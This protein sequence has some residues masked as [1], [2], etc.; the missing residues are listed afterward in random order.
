MHETAFIAGKAVPPRRLGCLK[1]ISDWRAH[2]DALP[3]CLAR[4]G[5]V[6]LRNA[7][8]RDQVMA[9]R[10]DVLERLAAVGEIA[11]PLAAA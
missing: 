6:L 11:E 1:E 3:Q 7:L 8:G 9:A 4:D 5:Y 10:L 2:R